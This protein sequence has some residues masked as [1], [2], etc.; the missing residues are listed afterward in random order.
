MQN[1]VLNCVL[2]ALLLALPLK[3]G[4]NEV[5]RPR[6]HSQL[7]ASYL[8]KLPQYTEW[9]RD[10][11][12]DEKAPFVIGILGTDPFEEVNDGKTRA[13]ELAMQA[14]LRQLGI[15]EMIRIKTGETNLISRKLLIKVF[16]A[17]QEEIAGCHLL[18]V[19]SSMEKRWPDALKLIEKSSVLTVGDTSDF[20]DHEGMI[21][22]FVRKTV[23]GKEKM[24][25]GINLVAARRNNLKL[26]SALYSAAERRIKG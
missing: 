16:A 3:A 2:M 4:E 21:N 18:F 9:P 24:S 11:F 12:A 14:I 20:I 19:S 22:C 13:G 7:L 10:T 23:D 15:G 26:D 6:T 25:L 8:Y 5:V 1:P 17:P